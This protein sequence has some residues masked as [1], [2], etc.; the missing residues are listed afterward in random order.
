MGYQPF[1]PILVPP[2][3]SWPP[4][5]V[6]AFRWLIFEMLFT[7]GSVLDCSGLYFMEFPDSPRAED[8][9]TGT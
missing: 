7:V 3:Y 9:G 4:R 5:A 2:L 1:E 8:G 6:A